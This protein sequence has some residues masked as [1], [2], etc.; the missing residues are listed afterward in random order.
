[1]N[2]LHLIFYLLIYLSGII[3]ENSEKYVVY[4]TIEFVLS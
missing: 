3:I 4:C 1:M 2:S